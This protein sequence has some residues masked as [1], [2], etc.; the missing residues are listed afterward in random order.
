MIQ[1][2]LTLDT[3][4][5]RVDAKDWEEAVRTAGDL[6]YRKGVVEERYIDH[7]VQIVKEIGP[8]I[9]LIKGVALA[10]ARPEDGAKAIGLS[11]VTLKKPICFGNKE[12]DPVNLVFALS[13]VDNSSHLDLIREMA[14]VFE[15]EQELE[16]LANCETEEE[17]LTIIRK[18]T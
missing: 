8:Y 11:L 9:V 3:V 12:N 13:A 14:L 7:M 4:R 1:D 16:Q 10:H 17:M 15:N 18:V 5:A 6:L 2:V